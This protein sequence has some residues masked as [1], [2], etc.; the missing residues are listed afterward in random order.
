ML[1]LLDLQLCFPA[2]VERLDDIAGDLC[3]SHEQHQMF[4]R[5]F[6]FDRFH[7]D[8]GQSL[9]GLLGEAARDLLARNAGADARLSHV[10]HCHTL[11]T[12][13]IID[14][15]HGETLAAFSR[16]ET[17]VFSVAMGHC[18]T[19]LSAFNL[20]E[21]LL[22]EDDVALVLIGE[23]AFHPIIRVIENATIMGEAACAIL[24]GRGNGPYQVIA[25]ATHHDG[26]F[27][28]LKGV[29]HD[30]SQDGF[31]TAYVDFACDSILRAL[32]GFGIGVADLRRILPHNVNIPSWAKITKK[33]GIGLDQVEL[34]TLPHYGHC[35]GADPF[36]NLQH[37]RKREAIGTSDLVLL[38]SIGL[39]ATA[40]S[41]LIS[42]N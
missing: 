12:T 13:S 40:S 21:G 41:A 2:R 9:H 28:I 4:G 26:R 18:A 20:L 30:P 34:S 39:G 19:G 17:D 10:I 37:A 27:A 8:P 35:F 38:F 36:I 32:D 11:P 3:L 29:P 15:A 14:G 5:F 23:K 24:V 1:T 42:V 22:T 16:H 7:C 31:E 6:G 25:S 33:L